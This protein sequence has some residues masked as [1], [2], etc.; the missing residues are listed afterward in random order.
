MYSDR[1]GRSV[2]ISRHASNR[3]KERSISAGELSDLIEHGQT[4]Y[5]DETRLWIAHHFADRSDNLL[6]VPVVLEGEF[7]IVKTVMHHFSW[8]V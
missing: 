5:K 1:F 3:M 2:R 4:R 6:C 7:L 8:E